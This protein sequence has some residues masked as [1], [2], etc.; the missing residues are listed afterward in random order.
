MHHGKTKY[1][2]GKSTERVHK[3]VSFIAVNVW[4]VPALSTVKFM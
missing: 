3:N 2:M 4:V 1:P